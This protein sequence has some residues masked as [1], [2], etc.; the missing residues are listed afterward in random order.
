MGLLGYVVGNRREEIAV[1]KHWRG[2]ILNCLGEACF[3]PWQGLT[4]GFNRA[5]HM[6][7][8]ILSIEGLGKNRTE[9]GIPYVVGIHV[10]WGIFEGR[11]CWR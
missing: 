3:S 2:K 9:E 6:G 4:I 1:G 7:C 5:S 8:M 11:K 10:D